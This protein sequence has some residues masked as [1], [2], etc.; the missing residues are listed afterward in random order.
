MSTPVFHPPGAVRLVTPAEAAAGAARRDARPSDSVQPRRGG[1][2]TMANFGVHYAYPLPERLPT[3]PARLAVAPARG[4]SRTLPAR[5][6]AVVRR[7][8][9][10]ALRALDEAPFDLAWPPSPHAPLDRAAWRTARAAATPA[11]AA[12]AEP[13]RRAA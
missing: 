4:G 9:A 3:A 6:A 12:P 10:A 2:E 5:A 7:V 1:R 8:A 11:P 13:L